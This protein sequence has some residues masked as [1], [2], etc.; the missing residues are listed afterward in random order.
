MPPHFVPPFPAS[1]LSSFPP[2][3]TAPNPLPPPPLGF[4]Q[5][6]QQQPFSTGAFVPPPPPVP[7]VAAG[8]SRLNCIDVD[9][10]PS[11]HNAQ[12]PMGRSSAGFELE[13]ENVASAG[14]RVQMA[15]FNAC[16]P[17]EAARALEPLDDLEERRAIPDDVEPRLPARNVHLAAAAAAAAA[18]ATGAPVFTKKVPPLCS[19]DRFG[20]T[21]IHTGRCI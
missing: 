16:T 15:T 21:S 17:A 5:S 7:F 8:S 4:A 20:E 1:R 14:P 18:T 6:M 3:V 2:A 10:P 19:A 11:Q 9:T 13:A 12:A